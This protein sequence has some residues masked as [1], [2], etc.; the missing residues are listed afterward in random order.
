MWQRPAPLW[1]VLRQVLPMV[2]HSGRRH[3]SF[4]AG[5]KAK[6]YHRKTEKSGCLTLTYLVDLWLNQAHWALQVSCKRAVHIVPTINIYTMPDIGESIQ[7]LSDMLQSHSIE[8]S[9]VCIQ[10]RVAHIV[11]AIIIYTMPD[12]GESIQSLFSTLQSLSFRLSRVCIHKRV[13]HNVPT[14]NIYNA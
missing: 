1:R 6:E 5:E 7:S 10:K 3:D 12:I 14:I 11:P 4:E 9:R 8:L 13:I 2:H